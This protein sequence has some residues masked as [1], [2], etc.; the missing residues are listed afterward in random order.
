VVN[1]QGDCLDWSQSAQN[2]SFDS[3]SS[4]GVVVRACSLARPASAAVDRRERWTEFDSNM[5]SFLFIWILLQKHGKTPA[6]GEATRCEAE[7]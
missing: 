2:S 4:V 1:T 6:R 7:E 5:T 3:S